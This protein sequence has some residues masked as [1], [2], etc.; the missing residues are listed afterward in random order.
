MESGCSVSTSVEAPLI[1]VDGI[2]RPLLRR[3][4]T[5]LTVTNYPNPFSDQTALTITL[6]GEGA[7]SVHLLDTQGRRVRTLLSAVLPAGSYEQRFDASQL[8]PGEY[9]VL[10]R[11]DGRE[12]VRRI[13][14]VR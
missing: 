3:R 5:A 8:A 9:T 10:L 14:C 13:L 12:A 6:P 2:C 7:V 4:A 11:A 1:I